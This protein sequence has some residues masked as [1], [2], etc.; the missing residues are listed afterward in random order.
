M[1]AVVG[2]SFYFDFEVRLMELLQGLLGEKGALLISHLSALGETFVFILIL[3]FLYW[4]IDKKTGIKV[5]TGLMFAICLNPMVKNIANRRRPY[6]DNT[7]IK[8]FRPVEKGAD[9]YDIAA[10]GFSFPSGHSTNSAAVYGGLARSYKNKLIKALGIILPLLVGISR[11]I[12]GVHYPTDVLCGWIMGY[13]IILIVPAILDKAGDEKRWLVFAC[14]SLISILGVFYCKTDDYFTGLGLLLGF[15]L[16]VEIEE[17]FIKFENT[18]KP[19]EIIVRLL[20]GVVIF[21]AITGLLKLPF[22][23]EVLKRGDFVA[24]LIRV[25]RY[26]IA[27]VVSIG[28]YP[29]CFGFLTRIL[30][31]Q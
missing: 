21:V 11:V 1:E 17:R 6:F 12:V 22:P 30:N 24:H 28:L 25:M 5:G 19:L 3:G 29:A 18:R 26:F 16:G 27:M 15:T 10:Q 9:I 8:C 2:N 20:L 4:G 14:L 13:A 23:S 7:G 31:R